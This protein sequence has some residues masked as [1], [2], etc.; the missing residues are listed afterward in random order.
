VPGDP[1][2]GP[3]VPTPPA[4]KVAP[5]TGA[6][7]VNAEEAWRKDQP[8]PAAQRPITLPTPQSFQLPNGL[9]VLHYERPGM[10][11]VAASLVIKTGGD[12]NPADRAGLANFTGAMLDQ[13]TASRD[14]LTIADDVAHLGASLSTS[15]A[16]D[17][18]FVTVQSLRK[19]FGAALDL[20]ADVALHPS[21]PDKEIDRERASRLGGLIQSRQD[22]N[23]VAQ[24]VAVR[25]LYGDNHPYG[26]IELGTESSIQAT[27]R[28]D[29]ANFWKQNFVPNNAALVVAGPIGQADVKALAEKAFASWAKGAPAAGASDTFVTAPVRLVL[30]DRPGAEQTQLRVAEIG[31]PRS[32]SD[33]AAVNVMNLILGGLFSSRINLNLREA[34]GYTYGAFSQFIFR[35]HAGPFWVGSGV[36][37][38]VTAPAVAEIMK[39]L[40]RMTDTTVSAD[41]LNMGRDALA[42]SLPADFETSSSAVDSL[43]GLFI[44]NLGLDY[45]TTFPAAVSTVT[46]D[47]VQAAARKYLHPDK[48][49][50]IAVGDRKKIEAD[51]R[52]LNLGAVEIRS[53]DGSI[54]K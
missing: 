6:E 49:I 12:S 10:P 48:I 51:L 35:K 7:A 52:K 14:A 5:G 42:R 29:M 1:N 43:S 16:K 45:Y 15:S 46:V 28:D 17:A 30:V 50:V 34:H 26:Y 25:V 33:Y 38:N 31:A 11:V 47:A 32:V 13:G 8:K 24:T 18:S 53:V 3:Q 4:P 9:T 37:T 41:E 27:K 39:E 19:N 22:P 54:R 21:F 36:R 44:Y 23:A 2:L 20:L 40:K